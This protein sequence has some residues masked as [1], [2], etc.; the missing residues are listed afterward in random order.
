MA[1]LDWR[2]VELNQGVFREPTPDDSRIILWI[3]GKEEEG[4]RGWE[5]I[6]NVPGAKIVEEEG[7]CFT[8]ATS[9]PA[10]QKVSGILG[11]LFHAFRK[12]GA[13]NSWVLPTGGS[14]E[15]AGDR[16]TGMMLIWPAPE[17]P[18]WDEASL[19]A[20]FRIGWQL[21]K[22]GKKL[23]AAMPAQQGFMNTDVVPDVLGKPREKA[24]ELLKAARAGGDRRAQALALTDLG[25]ACTR[26]EPR[27]AKEML[28]EAV[29][30]G[31]QLGD[32]S[33]ENDALGHLGM[34]LWASGEEQR[35]M[36]LLEKASTHAKEAKDRFLEK[37]VLAGQAIILAGLKKYEK[38][39]DV[40]QQALT[41]AVET[42]DRNHEAELLWFQAVQHAELGRRERAASLAQA[43]IDIHAVLRSP[44]VRWLSNHLKQFRPI[45]IRKGPSGPPPGGYYTGPTATPPEPEGE[46]NAGLL[47][48]AMNAVQAMDKSAQSGM[49]TVAPPIYQQ[50]LE[51]C[52]SCP[53]HTGARCKACGSFTSTKA[54]LPHE[55]CPLGKWND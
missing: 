20:R 43:A 48:T 55:Q 5:R 51:T 25:I 38:A 41:L 32:N 15:Q 13:V 53:H 16:L 39:L 21:R 24:E 52:A 22:I 9:L 26:S 17:T 45:V 44:H 30:L 14:A 28:E 37:N 50:R 33:G 6:T 23:F 49:K 7:L 34:A 18:S 19:Q 2:T 47:K 8:E 3:A 35:A 54:W 11:K 12:T 10:R 31:R 29:A 4:Y 42:G 1:K 27:R 40:S 36:E 46:C